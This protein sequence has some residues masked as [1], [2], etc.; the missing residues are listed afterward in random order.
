MMQYKYNRFN[1]SAVLLQAMLPFNY[2]V[3]R[4]LWFRK[5]PQVKVTTV[6][7]W[8]RECTLCRL[9]FTF[10]QTLGTK[11]QLFRNCCF[12][13]VDIVFFLFTQLES[14]YDCKRGLWIQ[15]YHKSE[16]ERV[17][18][19]IIIKFPGN[20]A[21]SLDPYISLGPVYKG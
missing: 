13:I 10:G 15:M 3:M 7:N 19:F 16:T 8:G 11:H 18:Q 9:L 6:N 21:R 12:R 20:L 5:Y 2:I 17:I 1:Y 4:C 14:G